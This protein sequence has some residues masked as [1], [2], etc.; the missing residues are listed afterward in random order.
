[1]RAGEIS[2]TARREEGDVVISVRDT[3]VGIAPEKLPGVFDLFM[4]VEPHGRRA[5]GGLGIGLTLV[6]RLVEMHG[7]RVEAH[8]AG[9]G[10][11]SE[12]VVRLPLAA[13]SARRAET[14]RTR[15]TL[16][17]GQ[18]PRVLVVDDNRDAAESLAL[19]LEMLGATTRVE[20]SGAAA[21]AVMAVYRPTIVILDIGM[22]GM[23][24]H[25]VARRIRSR[26]EFDDVTLVA[27]TGWGQAEDRRRSRAAGFDRH[28]IKPA[29]LD[30]LR[31]LTEWVPERD[32]GPV[33]AA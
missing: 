28:L 29:P 16:N 5:Q 9:R 22:P 33:P 26:V 12:F 19:L 3:G 21:L 1:M 13:A 7:G 30:D 14:A 18:S 2:L 23:D 17:P 11:G 10:R 27:L 24:G 31:A 8:S 15:D 20:S 25:E 32:R 4:Q 6:K